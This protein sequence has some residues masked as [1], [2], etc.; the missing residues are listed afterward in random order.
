MKVAGWA[1]ASLKDAGAKAEG[2]KTNEAAAE[3]S[4]GEYLLE[5]LKILLLSLFAAPRQ[6]F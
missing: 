3:G 6:F 1:E 2:S 5:V 4:N